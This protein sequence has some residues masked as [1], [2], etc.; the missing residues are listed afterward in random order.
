M[1]F[2]AA[3]TP[4][5]QSRVTVSAEKGRLEA[6]VYVPGDRMHI[7]LQLS[8]TVKARALPHIRNA[9]ERAKDWLV[10]PGTM[11]SPCEKYLHEALEQLSTATT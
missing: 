7:G 5:T 11:W 4:R 9:R 10:A 8:S 3:W 2:N 1:I 6:R